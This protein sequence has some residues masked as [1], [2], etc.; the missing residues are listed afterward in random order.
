VDPS[1]ERDAEEFGRHVRMRG[2]RLGLLVARCV[3]SRQGARTSLPGS[4]VTQSAFARAAGVSRN[5]VSAC[6]AAWDAA[7]E[8]GVVPERSTLTP[9]VDPEIRFDALPEWATYYVRANHGA[10]RTTGG[11]DEWYTRPEFVTAAR[12]VL[13]GID[14][15]PASCAK[16]QEVVQAERY[17][18]LSERGEDGLRQEWAGRVFLNPPFSIA[19]KFGSKLLAH[20]DAGDVSAAVMVTN[21]YSADARWYEPFQD[22]PWCLAKG[23]AFY[24]PD[25]PQRSQPVVWAGFV[26]LG[27]EFDAFTETFS[28]LGRVYKDPSGREWHKRFSRPPV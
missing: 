22:Y 21:A 6:L 15:D 3:K 17:Y 27:H 18:S 26:Y 14:L 2:W 20:Y 11:D 5:T 28:A 10:W 8:A 13:G 9:G 1:V 16:A 25:V 24:K 4:K 7:A 12:T 19:N 23:A